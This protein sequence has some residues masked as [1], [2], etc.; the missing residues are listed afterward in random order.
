ML[1]LWELAGRDDVR[2]STFSWRTRHGAPSQGSR[3]S[4]PIRSRSATRPA[5]AFSGQTK[6]PIV[7]ADDRVVSDSWAIAVFLERE[8]P[9]RPSLF[10]G[11]VGE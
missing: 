6:V 7:K 2:F 1:E 8:F 5:I 10:G 11:P 3:I 4:S 9:D